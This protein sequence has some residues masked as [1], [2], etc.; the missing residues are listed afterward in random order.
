MA[1]AQ[2]REPGFAGLLADRAGHGSVFLEGTA[3]AVAG[4]LIPLSLRRIRTV[5]FN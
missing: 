3:A 2:L 5:A 1:D 4:L